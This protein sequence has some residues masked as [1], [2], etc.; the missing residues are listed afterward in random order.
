MGADWWLGEFRNGYYDVVA[1]QYAIKISGGRET[2]DG[3]MISFLDVLAKNKEWPVVEAYTYEG[4]PASNLDQYFELKEGKIVGIKVHPDA[5]DQAHLDYQKR[6]TELIS[7]CQPVLTIL[8]PEKDKSLEQVF[9]DFVEK[10][11]E[12]PVV[13]VAR[14]PKAEDRE[15]RPGW[16]HLFSL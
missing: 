16:E 5:G 11:L 2:F 4:E 6:L 8:R 12:I 9:L 3:L 15:I 10:K 1:L 13:A 14:G 7:K